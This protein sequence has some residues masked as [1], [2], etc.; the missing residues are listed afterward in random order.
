MKTVTPFGTWPSVI[1]PAGVSGRLRLADARATSSGWVWLENRK[2]GAYFVQRSG[3]QLEEMCLPVSPRGGLA[4]GGG[5]FDCRATRLVYCGKDGCL[6]IRME[7]EPVFRAI[8]LP[9]G[10]TSSPTISA[11][12]QLAL[13]LHSDGVIDSI[14]LVSLAGDRWPIRLVQGADF[15]MQPCWHPSGNWIAWVE[16]NAPAMPWDASL[17]KLAAFSRG[18]ETPE[19]GV[20]IAG[21]ASTPVFQPEFSPNGRSLSYITGSGDTDELVLYDL[22]S[23]EKRILLRGKY[24]LPP[25]WVMGMRTYG[26]DSSSAS[27][28]IIIQNGDGTGSRV[29]RISVSSGEMEMLDLSPYTNFS[30]LVPSP[31]HPGFV[32]F[33]SSAMLSSSLVEWREGSF[34]ELRPGLSIPVSADDISIPEPVSWANPDGSIVH[35]LY[36]PP[37][38]PRCTAAGLPPAIIQIHGGPTA[39]AEATFSLET[40]YFT[41]RGY[42]VLAVNYRGSTG[43][44]RY[45][46]QSLNG[47]WGEYDVEDVLQGTRFLVENH[48][49]DPQHLVIKGSSAGG[50]T[51]LNALIREPELFRAAICSYPVANLHTILEE[52]FKFEAHYYDSLIGPYP[53]EKWKYDAWSP[54][55]RIAALRTPM[56]L[57]HGDA[58]PVVPRSQSDE[59]A[60]ALEQ[61]RVP[62]QYQV[63][64]GEGHG[65]KQSETIETYYRMIDD[66]LLRQ[67]IHG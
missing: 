5:E 57:F 32:C 47:Q 61:N 7:G 19:P 46:Q 52:T 42:A 20:I 58:D 4:Y 35:G 67:L 48:L 26:W 13:F 11:D 33:A 23:G 63:F 29:A 1:T 55:Q 49:A 40:S 12:G 30:Q 25:A 9:A 37:K 27:L 60:R 6:H 38:N 43:Y 59:I 14:G 36:Y 53:A 31:E 10:S 3:D 62:F 54:I 50:Y 64:P 41:S 66:F 51:L 8:P 18:E 15:Y 17:L 45:Y 56:L 21:D 2:D 65:W 24:L 22:G 34:H 39:A 44:G 16:W 28:F